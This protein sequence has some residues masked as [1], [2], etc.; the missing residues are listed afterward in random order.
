MRIAIEEAEMAGKRG[1]K[2]I[3]ALLD[4]NRLTIF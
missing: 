1:D 3:A 4:L 2:P